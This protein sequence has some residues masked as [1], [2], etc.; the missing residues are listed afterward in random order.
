MKLAFS[1][2]Q[3][4][5]FSKV[6]IQAAVYSLIS[7]VVSWLAIYCLLKQSFGHIG[8]V[9]PQ[10]HHTHTEVIPRIGGAGIAIGLLVTYLVCFFQFNAEDNK[11]LIH[12]AVVG[13]AVGAFS[14]GLIDDFYPLRANFKLLVQI[15]IAVIAYKCGLAVDR[16]TIPFTNTTADLE[17]W[18]LLLTVGW[19][20]SVMNLINLIDGLDGLAG[21]IG[22]MLM[23]LLAYLGM[24]Q[25]FL[26]SSIMAFGMIGAIIGFLLHNF[27]PAKCYMGDSGAYFIGFMIA[28]LSLLNSQ[29]GAVMAAMIGPALALALPI[30]DVAFAIMRRGLQ[31]LPLFRPDRGHIHHLLMKTGLSRRKTV[32]AI[33]AMSLFALVGGLVASIERGRHLPIFLG[34]AFVIVF[35]VLRGNNISTNSVWVFFTDSLHSR[36]DIRNALYLK[37]WLITEAER[38]DSI[39]HLW[40]DFR[41]VLKKM[42]FCRAGL[43][44]GEETCEF[45]I[46]HTPSE[47]SGNLWIET[48]EIRNSHTASLTLYGEK[49]N[50]SKNQFSLLTDIATETW[51]KAGH[52]WYEMNKR[53]IAFDAV[54]SDPKSYRY[55]KARNLYRPTY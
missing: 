43:T 22:L 31:G 49:D 26:F 33:Y 50:L 35:F 13:G 2:P 14:L 40:S 9:K 23:I 42:G 53:P 15:L 18:G 1:V 16:I 39:A 30:L 27:P 46:P 8:S 21:G 54:A 25:N 44:I 41:F 12:L 17:F 52:K 51:T 36:R 5:S 11:T 48:H 55:Q 45:Y 47:D 20:V 34:F 37:D 29:K 7:G 24:K 10:H 38:A 4:F 19:F 32:L 6:F 3:P 28:A